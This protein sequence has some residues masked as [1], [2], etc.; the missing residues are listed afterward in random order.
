MKPFLTSSS[1]FPVAALLAV[2]TLSSFSHGQV[3]EE[4]KKDPRAWLKAEVADLDKPAFTEGEPSVKDGSVPKSSPEAVLVKP[5]TSVPPVAEEGLVEVTKDVSLD[6]DG[7]E[8]LESLEVVEAVEAM[9][10][11]TAVIG[12]PVPLEIPLEAPAEVAVIDEGG[13]IPVVPVPV[14][15]VFPDPDAGVTELAEDSLPSAAL[16]ADFREE[17]P[18]LG[19]I[20]EQK[21]VVVPAGEDASRPLTLLERLERVSSGNDTEE[22][23]IRPEVV[24]E[25]G[26]GTGTVIVEVVEDEGPV[27]V[28]DMVEILEA[29]PVAAKPR[30]YADTSRGS[31]QLR[32]YRATRPVYPGD[33]Y[34]R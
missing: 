27:E 15:T 33:V 34:R 22:P 10:E 9:E 30:D 13:V 17:P 25:D 3:P 32:Y 29:P 26:E 14:E 19:A 1:G 8:S 24:V 16:D 20:V 5:K 11:P 23:V 6:S 7:L 4:N 12:E 28:F 2:V 31:T 21:D 18:V